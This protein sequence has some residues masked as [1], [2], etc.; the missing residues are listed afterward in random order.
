M[1]Y[2]LES[3]CRDTINENALDETLPVFVRKAAVQRIERLNGGL[4][5]V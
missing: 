2:E 1:P 3:S 4:G 5:D